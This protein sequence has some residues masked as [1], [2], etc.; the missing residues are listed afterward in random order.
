MKN[1]KRNLKISVAKQPWTDGLVA[2]R[3]VTF[4]E[5]LLTRLLGPPNKVMVLVPGDSVDTV[6][7]TE[8]PEGGETS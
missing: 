5:K 3:K 2:C 7:I 6:S 4:R 8:A 1:V